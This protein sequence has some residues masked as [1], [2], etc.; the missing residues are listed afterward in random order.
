MVSMVNVLFEK[1]HHEQ[2]KELQKKES[3]KKEE[4]VQGEKGSQLQQHS[5]E[6]K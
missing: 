4:K 6:H 5:L 3:N 2:F 1:Q